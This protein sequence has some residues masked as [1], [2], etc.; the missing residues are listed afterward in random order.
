[1]YTRYTALDVPPQPEHF[2]GNQNNGNRPPRTG[3]QSVLYKKP[4]ETM[5]LLI[6][7]IKL[8]IRHTEKEL[9]KA[10]QDIVRLVFVN[11]KNAYIYKKS[12]DARRKREIH[13]VYSVIVRV[14]EKEG[15][16][17]LNAGKKDVKEHI[18]HEIFDIKGTPVFDTRPVVVGTGPCGLFAAYI[19]ARQGCRPLV[20]ERGDTVERRV[21]KISDFWNGGELDSE[22]NVQFGEGGAGTFSDGKLNTRIGDPLERFILQTFVDCGAPPEILYQAKPHIGTDKLRG[23]VKKMRSRMIAWGGEVRFCTKLTGISVRGEQ[24]NGIIL[25]GTEEIPCNALILAIGH[26]SRDTYEMLCQNGIFMQP[27]AFAAGVRIEHRQEFINRMQYGN[28]ADELPAADYRVAYNG[29]ERSCYS[30]CMC[31]GGTV[32][33]ASSEPEQ[34][35]VNGMSNH[36]RD[37]MNANSALAVPVRPEDFGTD[38]VLGGMEFQRKYERLAYTLGNG[39]APIQLAEDFLRDK[40]TQKLNGVEPSFTGKTVFA[41]LRDCLPEFI[42]TTLKEGLRSFDDKIKGFSTGGALLTGV[43]M[44]T[45]APVRITRGESGESINCKGLYPAGEGAGYA[46]G[47]M[48][49]AIDGVKTA[50]K[51]IKANEKERN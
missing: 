6:S 50:V 39:A 33:N 41:P 15:R 27:K 3:E 47:I 38:A 7:N 30:F 1:M 2:F 40:V 4:G 51:L 21:Q 5:E 35:V 14:S 32:V 24:L 26:S 48:S 12:L 17:I 46:G 16:K 36:A 19:L 23:V 43:E 44:R 10:A 25:N 9:W 31:P 8:P 45:S 13:W 18:R 22:T 49:A 28:Y 20:V 29:A 11:E 34:L 37:G 42:V